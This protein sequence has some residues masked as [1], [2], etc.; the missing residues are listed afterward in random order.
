MKAQVKRARVEVDTNETSRRFARL[1]T[2]A[3]DMG[4]KPTLPRIEI[5]REV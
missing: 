4:V 3:E 2:N 1:K 5:I